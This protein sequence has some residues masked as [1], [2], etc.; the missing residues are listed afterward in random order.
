MV[1]DLERQQK[2]LD[3]ILSQFIFTVNIN[4]KRFGP[5]PGPF[6]MGIE[7]ERT[8]ISKMYKIQNLTL[9]THI[10]CKILKIFTLRMILE[11][12]FLNVF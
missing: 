3:W 6:S 1:E 10:F 4:P 12:Y 2:T 5:S 11:K 8:N 9:K 7:L